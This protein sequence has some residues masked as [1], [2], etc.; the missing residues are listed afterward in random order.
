MQTSSS[1]SK[2]TPPGGGGAT[3]Q[4]LSSGWNRVQNWETF[5]YLAIQGGSNEGNGANVIQWT[6]SFKPDGTTT[7]DQQWGLARNSEG[8]YSFRN[9]GTPDWKALTVNGN[10]NRNGERIIQW[11]YSAA[12]RFQQWYIDWWEGGPYFRLVNRGSGKCLAV[13]G[14]GNPANGTQIIQWECGLGADQFWVLY[15]E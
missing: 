12:N 14:G 2:G 5:K 8:F 1:A 4:A 13:A 6:Q 7:Y 9:A 11:Q 3:A 15:A 10:N